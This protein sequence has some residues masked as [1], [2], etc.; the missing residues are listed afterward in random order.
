M[1][2]YRW[3]NQSHPQTLVS[4]TILLYIDGV[5]GVLFGNYGGGLGILVSVAMVVGAFGIANDKKWGYG[6]ALAAAIL[7]VG[8]LV[9]YWGIGGVITNVNP[10]LSLLFDG[11]LVALLLHPMSRSYQRIWFR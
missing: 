11:A 9:S 7:N 10:L 1:N 4:A 6:L 3:L 8:F 5:L 2:G